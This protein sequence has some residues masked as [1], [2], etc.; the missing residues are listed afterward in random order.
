MHHW[1]P[2]GHQKKRITGIHS[3]STCPCCGSSHEDQ[4]HLFACQ[5]CEVKEARREA[6]D[7]IEAC[8]IN[9]N[10]P[11]AVIVA[12]MNA[13]RRTTGLTDR[14]RSFEC[15]HARKAAEAQSGLGSKAILRGHI[16]VEWYHVIKKHT[17]NG[18][19]LLILLHQVAEN[20]RSQWSSAQF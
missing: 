11:P 17:G 12:F 15:P 20:T 16:H 10:M 13:I 1:L 3:S 2:I 5:H 19:T 7:S 18:A 8:L 14:D 6:A 4:D 9:Q